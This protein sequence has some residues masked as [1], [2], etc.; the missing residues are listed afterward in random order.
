LLQ[1]DLGELV[2]RLEDESAAE[3]DKAQKAILALGREAL[4]GIRKHLEKTQDAE[5]RQRLQV[6]LDYWTKIRWERDAAAALE[7]A[8]QEGKLV[9][10]FSTIGEPDGYA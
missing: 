6:I 9:M 10:V 7:R 4:P 5:V 1:T 3:R 2:S 8:K